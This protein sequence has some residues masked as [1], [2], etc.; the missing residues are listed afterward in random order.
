[1]RTDSLHFTDPVREK[2]F[3]R[4]ISLIDDYKVAAK[5]KSDALDNEINAKIKEEVDKLA[6]TY[7]S[8]S[9][10]EIK[11]AEFR[12]ELA[13][14][15]LHDMKQF[16]I[17]FSARILGSDI[18]DDVRR[19]ALKAITPIYKLSKYHSKMVKVPSEE[20]LISDLVPRA[21][22]EW[23]DGLLLMRYKDLQQ[24]LKEASQAQDTK[25]MELIIEEL[26]GISELRRLVAKTI[27]DRIVSPWH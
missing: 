21:I 23:K 27:G 24:Q 18:D 4:V 3:N 1:M 19:F 22:S 5:E 16:A 8:I 12:S 10:L 11:E 15:K 6:A 26:Q 14:G 17:D 25:K 7:L 2:I 20:D 9:E 13:E